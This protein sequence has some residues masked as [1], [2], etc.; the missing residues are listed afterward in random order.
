MCNAERAPRELPVRLPPFLAGAYLFDLG[1]E[2]NILG[3]ARG[4]VQQAVEVQ[5]AID[6]AHDRGLAPTYPPDP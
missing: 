4:T 3:T 1:P 6:A 5:R 2:R